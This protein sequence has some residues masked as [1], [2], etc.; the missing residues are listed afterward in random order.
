MLRNKC[1]NDTRIPFNAL[2][3]VQPDLFSYDGEARDR[4]HRAPTYV[5]FHVD[6]VVLGCNIYPAYEL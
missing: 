2:V 5:Y 1:N 4:L 3:R 6:I